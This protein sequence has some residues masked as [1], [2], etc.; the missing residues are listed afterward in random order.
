MPDT[1]GSESPEFSIRHMRLARNAFFFLTALTFGGL[2]AMLAL[3]WPDLQFLGDWPIDSVRLRILI[4]AHGWIFGLCLA[5][6]NGLL[7]LSAITT[8][9]YWILNDHEL[10]RQGLIGKKRI[11][12]AHITCLSWWP[13]SRVIVVHGDNRRIP[14]FIDSMP[15]RQRY[16]VIQHLRH[17]VPEE[18]QKHWELFERMIFTKLDR[19]IHEMDSAN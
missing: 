14:L 7:L 11:R 17:H 19:R 2:A 16:A 10:L 4:E 8:R 15:H 13:V 5:V 18:R 9:E 6:G 3:L 12:L 1:S